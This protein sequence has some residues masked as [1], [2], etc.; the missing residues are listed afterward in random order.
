[1]CSACRSKQL[2]ESFDAAAKMQGLQDS[3]HISQ[4]DAFVNM[5][6]RIV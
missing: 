4:S 6:V 5:L 2:K 3:S 1:M